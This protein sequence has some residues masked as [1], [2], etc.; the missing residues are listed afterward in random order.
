MDNLGLLK[1]HSFP[2]QAYSWNNVFRSATRFSSDDEI[3]VPVRINA[4]VIS[5]QGTRQERE[6]RLEDALLW[7][8]KELAE[9]R[10]QDKFL[11][12]QF[13]QLRT[14]I[15]KLKAENTL[16]EEI[17]ANGSI[18]GTDSLGELSPRKAV[19]RARDGRPLVRK[20]YSMAI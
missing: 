10:H 13:I 16:L 5:S 12:R 4:P 14:T 20:S 6:Q 8:R 9:M 15:Q 11:T 17:Q 1:R 2:L 18:E 7:I 19:P 3:V